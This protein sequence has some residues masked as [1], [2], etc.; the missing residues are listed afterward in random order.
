MFFGFFNVMGKLL[1]LVLGG[2]FIIM[3]GE[4]RKIDILKIGI[5]GK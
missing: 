5:A 2:V 3:F 4:R 1:F